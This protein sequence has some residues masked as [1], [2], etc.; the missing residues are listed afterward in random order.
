MAG[1]SKTL[2][3][4][5]TCGA[6]AELTLV[7]KRIGTPFSVRWVR[8]SF[9]AGSMNL[10]AVR[11]YIG[12]D[13]EAPAAGEPSGTSV[14]RDYGQV[15]YLVGE[16]EQKVIEHMVEVREGGTWVKVYAVNSDFFDHAVDVQV[17]IQLGE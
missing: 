15:D 2:S 11:I 8:V 14:L 13:E 16:Q 17:G 6:R 3:F 5:G 9:P 12:A 7:S 1:E 10:L 4:F